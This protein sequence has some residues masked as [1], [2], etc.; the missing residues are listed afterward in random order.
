MHV[1]HFHVFEEVSELP[2]SLLWYDC[3]HSPL[4]TINAQLF[5]T[6]KKL[7]TSKLHKGREMQGQYAEAICIPH[8]SSYAYHHSKK[9]TKFLFFHMV[10]D[11]IM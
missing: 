10:M 5:M 9:Q 1:L 2:M 4:S 11:I 8:S 3:L 6:V 7:L